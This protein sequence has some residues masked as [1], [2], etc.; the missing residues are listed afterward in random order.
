[1]AM[2]DTSLCAIKSLGGKLRFFRK[3]WGLIEKR[4]EAW[5]QAIQEDG[6]IDPTVP[7]VNWKSFAT[8]TLSL[9]TFRSPCAHFLPPES[10]NARFLFVPADC[11]DAVAI[12]LPATG[13]HGFLRRLFS[14]AFWLRN[15]G[16]S[17][18]ILESPFYGSRRPLNQKGAL[19]RS[20]HELPDLGRATIEETAALLHLFR[21]KGYERQVVSGVSQGGLHAAMVAGLCRWPVGLA[22]AFAPHSAAPVFTRGLLSDVVDWDAL[23]G[24]STET[25]ERLAFAFNIT[26]IANFPDK[27]NSGKQLLIF[28]RGDR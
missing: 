28:A 17:S 16:V 19:L 15:R 9:G 11:T 4:H 18:V 26:D 22:A 7:H 8:A 12:H 3:G 6:F 20:V 1:M 27:K 23:G 25:R 14:Y 21:E 13:D 24:D 2:F 10:Q 5:L